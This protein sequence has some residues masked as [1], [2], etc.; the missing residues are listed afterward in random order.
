MLIIN[1][2]ALLLAGTAFLLRP[3]T[4]FADGLHCAHCRNH[5]SCRKYCRLVYEEKKVEVIC[6][7]GQEEDFCLP[8]PSKRGCKH[9]EL[10]C[11]DCN[12]TEGVITKPKR[13]VWYEWIPGCSSRIYTKN[14]LVKKTEIKKVPSYK[15]V[16]E[17]L[18]GPCRKNI[19]DM[20]VP[21]DA[22]IPSVPTIGEPV[23][24]VRL[25]TPSMER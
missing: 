2:R 20:A 14:K 9:C 5:G 10:V 15:W 4:V 3:L 8:G 7:G 18:C 24:F 23:Q 21:A 16:V 11:D 19:V 6:W 22:E 1:R 17:D 25:N 12:N 13:F